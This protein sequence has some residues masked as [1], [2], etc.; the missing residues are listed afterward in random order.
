[1]RGT[2]LAICL[3]LGACGGGGGDSTPAAAGTSVDKTASTGSPPAP[4]LPA[5]QVPAPPVPVPAAPEAPGVI[6]PASGDPAE[7]DVT[8]PCTLAPALAPSQTAARSKLTHW[9]A[10]GI[11]GK[12]IVWV[13]DSTTWH[14][15]PTGWQ[16]INTYYLTTY[17]TPA[18]ARLNGTIQVWQG[19]NG[20]SL[21][22]F[23][24]RQEL[25][26]AIAAQ[27]DLYI[28]SY[29]IN[30]VRLG[31]TSQETLTANLKTAINAIRNAVPNA[32]IV[33][34]MPNSLL[35]G[36]TSGAFYVKPNTPDAAQA[37]TDI[38]RNA[39]RSVGNEWPNVAL[40]DS[41]ALLFGELVQPA[42]QW[43][44]DQL[45]PSFKGYTTILDQLAEIIGAAPAGQCPP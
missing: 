40:Y 15:S 5:V 39:Y 24:V 32:D 28:F 38:L 44:V 14:L 8:P 31:T 25:Q 27:G 23:L 10:G 16:G 37:Y 34:R 30:D 41:Q 29:G 1:M 45:H 22:G 9:F 2:L 3:L 6:T 26:D 35:A 21:A 12:K 43:M 36:D 4:S 13:G 11:S 17:V 42:S 7:P 33:L 19:S 18:S 20:N